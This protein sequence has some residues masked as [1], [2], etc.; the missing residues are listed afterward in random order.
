M[1]E[2]TT[3]RLLAQ[4]PRRLP[5][6]AGPTAGLVA[7]VALFALLVGLREGAT[8][9]AH[10][11][12]VRNLQLIAYEGTVTG[13]LALGMLLVIV[14]GGIDLSVGSVV[15]LVTV[16]AMLTY[17]ALLDLT[18]SMAL[19]SLG[20]IPAGVLAGGACGLTNGA[21]IAGLRVSPFVATLGMLSA[22]R[23]LA[24]FLAEGKTIAFPGGVKPEWARAVTLVL[25]PRG[26]FNPGTWS[27][28]LLAL[29]VAIFLRATVLG[30]YCY[31]I[32]SN[33]AT[34]RLCGVSVGRSKVILYTLAGLLAGW[35]G[36]LRF[37]SVGG[38]P[39]GSQGLELEVIA[40][41][42]I[43]GASLAGGQGTVGGTLVGVFLLGV[44][45]N[46]VRLLY[47]PVEI[48]YLVIGGVIIISTA[49]GRWQR[50]GEG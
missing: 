46:G 47:L 29:L 40:A 26:L 48:R 33:E 15:A 25:P 42:V 34:A 35:A 9:L 49:L 19:A 50:R 41:V 23:G 38:D 12:S 32:G 18:G 2:S 45:L 43:G 14:N 31:A 24:L 16:A 10:Y 4:L 28:F 13:I 8:G 22:A 7:I 36:V 21:V 30:R 44:L 27:L 20:A 6:T 17:R 39:A 5:L 11:L 1:S 37:A 3:S